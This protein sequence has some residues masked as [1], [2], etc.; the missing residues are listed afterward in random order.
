MHNLKDIIQI[1]GARPDTV[2]HLGAGYCSEHSLYQNIGAHKTIF[3]EANPELVTQARQLYKTAETVT[4]KQFAVNIDEKPVTLNISNNPRFSSLLKPDH[5][6]DYYPNICIE[7][8]TEVN[9]C[10][11]EGLCQSEGLSSERE[12][13]LVSEIQGMEKV[14][15]L[16]ADPKCLQ[17]FKWIVISTNDENLFSEADEVSVRDMTIMLEAAA[18]TTLVFSD[19]T[20]PFS[21]IACV[22]NDAAAENLKLLERAEAL[23]KSHKEY[24]FLGEYY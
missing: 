9:G 2:L 1:I 18:F 4:V 14:I 21:T 13:L 5:L 10:T 15:F 7:Q 12:N 6:L 16:R 19:G 20:T 24:K 3:V 8:Q 17:K 22:R 11:L 23:L